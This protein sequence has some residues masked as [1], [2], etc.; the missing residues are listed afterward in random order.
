ISKQQYD[1]QAALVG[2][3]EGTVKS[4]E[5]AIASAKLQVQYSHI[6]AP[7]A[8]R[9]GLRLVD[10]GNIVHAADQN[11]LALITQVQPIAVLFTTPED[12]LPALMR[13]LQSGMSLPPEADDRSARVQIV[14]NNLLTTDN[15][16]DP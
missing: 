1:D 9:V 15:Q 13:R 16:I 11:G 3:Y 10:V 12:R 5:G 2:Q 14:V 4:D 8:G 6:T 7:I